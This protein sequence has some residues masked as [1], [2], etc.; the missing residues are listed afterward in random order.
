[1]LASITFSFGLFAFIASV[2][3]GPTNLLAMHSG[4][5][6][7]ITSSL[8]FVL[9]GSAGSAL[10]L[11]MVASGL[12]ELFSSVALLQQLLALLGSAWLTLMAWKL[13]RLSTLT[14]AN[15]Q[16]AGFYQGFAMQFI[17][18]KTWAMAATA[19]SLYPSTSGLVSWQLAAIFFVVTIPCIALWAG[20]GHWLKLC[21]QPRLEQ[22]LCQ[23]LAL[24]LVAMV[25]LSL[26]RS[27]TT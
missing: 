16:P 17:N 9:G 21:R 3:P 15:S 22:R 1:M 11:W 23:L 6:V 27:L 25:W 7:G 20:L 5:R 10:L 18:P 12:A 19:S 26:I 13:F 24:S 4:T 2:T 14:L 8:P